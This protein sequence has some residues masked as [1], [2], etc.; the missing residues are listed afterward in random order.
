LFDDG[1]LKG[2][3]I[4]NIIKFL[5]RIGYPL[6]LQRFSYMNKNIAKKK[7]SF[8][9]NNKFDKFG[10]LFFRKLENIGIIIIQFSMMCKSK[11]LI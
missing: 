7:Y 5:F 10:I 4:P 1:L 11:Q 9:N 8:F 3:L 6:F 2:S